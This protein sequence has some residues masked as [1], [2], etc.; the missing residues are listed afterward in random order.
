MVRR[1]GEIDAAISI[2]ALGRLGVKQLTAGS[3]LDLLIIYDAAP[4]IFSN[5]QRKLPAA[6]YVLRLAQTMVSWIST[7]TAEGT[8]YDVDLRLRP[9]G[10]AGA[11]ATS[12][13]RL[14][15]YFDRDAWIW[16]KQALTKARPIA[17]DTGL[18]EKI[19]QLIN[20]IVNHNHPKECL[21][22]AISDM[23]QRIRK[24]QKPASQWDLRQITGGL[25][26][27]DLLIQAW[28]LQYGALFSASAQPTQVI[29]QT[30]YEQGM[31]DSNCYENMTEASKCLNE[32]HHCL[33]LTLGPVAPATDSLLHGL[34]QFMQKRLDFPDETRFQHHFDLSISTVIQSL[35]G[36][37]T[38][39]DKTS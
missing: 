17:G 28:R 27:I 19:Q 9:E 33:R 5:G 22:T 13:D 3:D 35:K 36:Y 30:L 7:P 39:A 6:S 31:I 26:D 38:I 16:E 4:D 15:T 32:I 2:V 18:S 14:A 29:L 1:Y 10:Q 21:V 25:T 11:I 20:N 12:I 23:R 34:H 37:L 24:Q 8:L